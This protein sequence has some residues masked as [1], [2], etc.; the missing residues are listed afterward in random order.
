MR[1]FFNY[2]QE[3]T[4]KLNGASVTSIRV[5]AYGGFG[6]EDFDLCPECVDKLYDFLSRGAKDEG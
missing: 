1:K 3:T 2:R 4:K 5:I 6:Y